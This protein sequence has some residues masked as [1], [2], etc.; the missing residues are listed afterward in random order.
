MMRSIAVALC[1]LASTGSIAAR[2]D[3][4]PENLVHST[5]DVILA[6]I[7]KNR[8]LYANNYD[9]LYKMAEE[10]VL[11]HFDFRRMSQWVLGRAWRTATAEQRDKFVSEFR[12]LLVGTYSTALLS[13]KDQEIVYLPVPFK[14]TDTEALVKTEVKQGGGQPNIPIHY[15]FYKNAQGAWKVYDIKIDGVSIVVNYRSV[16]ATKIRDK[17]L[18]ALIEEIS[19]GNKKKHNVSKK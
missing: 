11:P 16:Y 4:T 18:D 17:G 10:K 19:A 15:D 7:K 3:M 1:I 6:E 5:A 13:Y 9:R 2:A 8:Q 14:P 12:D